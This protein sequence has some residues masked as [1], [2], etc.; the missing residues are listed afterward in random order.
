MRNS[1]QNIAKSLMVLVL[2]VIMVS[3]GHA[4]VGVLGK[5]RPQP[6]A[7]YMVVL[8]NGDVISGSFVE[9]T[10]SPEYGEGVKLETELGVAAFYEEQISKIV[11]AGEYYRYSSRGMILPT[12]YPI[13]DDHYVALSELLLPHAGFGIADLVSISGACSIIPMDKI[14]GQIAY[15][16]A[17]F[18]LFNDKID[19]DLGNLAIAPGINYASFGKRNDILHAFVA[20]SLQ[21]NSVTLNTDL[22]YKVSGGDLYSY[23]L[24]DNLWDFEYPDGA[25]GLSFTIDKQLNRNGTHLLVEIINGNVTDYKKTA[26]GAGI[27]FSNSSFGA[28]L[29]LMYAVGT[30]FPIP[31]MQF[32]YTPF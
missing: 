31:V 23:R 5:F 14:T 16:N 2:T 26:V 20:L 6:E 29:G 9:F 11:L 13:G 1:N 21:L 32:F 24:D 7:D 19:E 3:V 15:V 22:F 12:A 17:K 25:F 4:K 8:K 30:N 27:R 10:H 18:T 28:D